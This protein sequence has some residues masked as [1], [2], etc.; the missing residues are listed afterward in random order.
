MNKNNI[1]ITIKKELRSIFRDKKT[2]FMILGFPFIIALF[3]VFFGSMEGI[4]NGNTETKYN[5]GFNYEINDV[6]KELLKQNNLVYKKFNEASDMKKAYDAGD[7]SAYIDYEKD[8]N[9]YVIY[10]DSDMS[11]MTVTGYVSSYLDG[12]NKYLGDIK[13]VKNDIDPVDIYNNFSVEMKNVTGEELTANSFMV[14]LIVG[15]AFT[16]IIMAISL[17][18]VNMATSAIAVEKEHGTLETVLTLPITTNELIIGKYLATVIIG[19]ISS[20]IGFIITIVSFGISKNFFTMY[21]EFS[22]SFGAVLWG[23]IIC[24]F[25]SFLIGGLAIFLTSSAKTYK[26]AQAAGQILSIVCIIPMFLSYLSVTIS[27][28]FYM[29]PIINYTTI[30]MD[31]YSGELDYINLFITLGS[32]IVYVLAI[33]AIILKKFRSEKVLFGA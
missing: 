18:A 3:V 2:L 22:I 4:M 33:L 9:N 15:I 17:A 21:S 26:E 32:T 8:K 29:I 13:L 14:E 30:L 20:I 28:T 27:E 16:Y 6:E 19:S 12:Y 31:L 1:L 25:A 7:I 23:I 10:S 5:I 24:I 11:G